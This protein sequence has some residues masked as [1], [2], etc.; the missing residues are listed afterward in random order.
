MLNKPETSPGS[1]CHD[2]ADTAGR[3]RPERNSPRCTRREFRSTNFRMRRNFRNVRAILIFGVDIE[4]AADDLFFMAGYPNCTQGN[5]P[6]LQ[7]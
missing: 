6:S 4:A 5:T 3:V 1:A 7:P 2:D